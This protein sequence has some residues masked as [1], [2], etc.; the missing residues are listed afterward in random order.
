M[1]TRRHGNLRLRTE[2]A[3]EASVQLERDGYAVLRGVLD[4]GEVAA[5]RDG[6]GGG[7][8]RDAAGPGA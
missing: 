2:P 7:V 8:R 6:G 5:L 3:P 1:I 4:A